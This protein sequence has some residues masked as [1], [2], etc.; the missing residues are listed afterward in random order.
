MTNI[1]GFVNR[2]LKNNDSRI[3]NQVFSHLVVN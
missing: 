2:Q 3:K 1:L